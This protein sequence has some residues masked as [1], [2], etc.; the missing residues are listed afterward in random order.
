MGPFDVQPSEEQGRQE[1]CLRFNESTLASVTGW[2]R[3]RLPKVAMLLLGAEQIR[4]L[5]FSLANGALWIMSWASPVSSSVR[6]AA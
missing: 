6:F 5:I 2:A 3:M 4:R 1:M